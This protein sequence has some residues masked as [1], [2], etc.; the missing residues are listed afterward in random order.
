MQEHSDQATPRRTQL[1]GS[2]A[3]LIAL[4]VAAIVTV[5]LSMTGDATTPPAE[6]GQPVSF[7][8]GPAPPPTPSITAPSSTPPS[9][10]SPGSMGAASPAPTTFGSIAT[11][12]GSA[13]VVALEP[14]TEAGGGLP[15]VEVAPANVTPASGEACPSPPAAAPSQAGPAESGADDAE[16]LSAPAW[17][18]DD[19]DPVSMEWQPL[20]GTWVEDGGTYTQLDGAG[21]DLITELRLDPPPQYRVGVEV[22]A[23]GPALGAGLLVGQPVPGSRSGAVVVDFTDGGRFLRWGSYDGTTGQYR[24][25][26]GVAMPEDF[27]IT[28]EHRLE[29]EVRSTR[30]LVVVDGREIGAFDPVSFGRTGLVTSVASVAFADF[31]IEEIAP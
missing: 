2:T 17:Y 8:D 18:R 23:R 13:T 29:V 22:A 25:A 11:D 30:T 6:A 21:Y 1:P 4:V 28:A 5:A 27:D 16:P 26:G 20:S 14:S 24:Y 3:R 19:F 7:S 12:D 10:P 31:V 9:T 15:S